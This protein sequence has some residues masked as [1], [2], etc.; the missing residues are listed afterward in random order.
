MSLLTPFNVNCHAS[1]GRKVL[2][3]KLISFKSLNTSK[4]FICNINILDI[5]VC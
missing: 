5:L 2:N 1:D 4:S 3:L